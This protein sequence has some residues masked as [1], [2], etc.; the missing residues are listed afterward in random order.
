MAELTPEQEILVAQ[1][2]ERNKKT[3]ADM[4]PQDTLR[5]RIKAK[6]FDML[7]NPWNKWG[8]PGEARNAA[9]DAKYSKK[10]SDYRAGSPIKEEEIY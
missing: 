10:G 1:A 2:I 8:T 7:P 3:G 5:G 4:F 9:I 6:L